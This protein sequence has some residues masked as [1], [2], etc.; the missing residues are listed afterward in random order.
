MTERKVTTR[1]LLTL[2]RGPEWLSRDAHIVIFARSVRTLGYGCTSI[3]VAGM[4]S[5]DGVTALGIGVLLG[6]AA[7]GSVTA[8]VSMGVFADRLGRRRSLLERQVHVRAELGEGVRR[9]VPA[10]S[11]FQHHL[12]C[13]SGAGHHLRQVLRVVGDPHRLQPLARIGHAHQHAATAM[14]THSDDLAA[15][16]LFRLPAASS[17]RWVRAPRA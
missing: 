14:N 12:R 4:L 9:P 10:V 3:L 7:L 1:R 17:N 13:F 8:S 5:E 6:V 2:L 15:C 16:V 11:G